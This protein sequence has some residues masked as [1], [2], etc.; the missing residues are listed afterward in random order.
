[1]NFFVGLLIG[2]ILGFVG[3]IAGHYLA[4]RSKK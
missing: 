3:A 1:M 4:K 2:L